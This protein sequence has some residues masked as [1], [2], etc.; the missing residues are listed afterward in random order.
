M[1]F[2]PLIKEQVFS[3]CCTCICRCQW[4]FL[5]KA[6]FWAECGTLSLPGSLTSARV[7]CCRLICWQRDRA[8]ELHSLLIST[9]H[10]D[11]YIRFLWW[12]LI[13]LSLCMCVCV[14]FMVHGEAPHTCSA[15]I[16]AYKNIGH[17]MNALLSTTSDALMWN[18]Q[19]YKRAKHRGAWP[20]TH[21]KSPHPP[22][23]H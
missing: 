6:G 23:F 11:H 9:L 12:R 3:V 22:P 21:M 14:G 17:C 1:L 8:Y 20:G 7:L 19:G 13:A 5:W 10:G 4:A 15:N 16:N 18:T 2:T